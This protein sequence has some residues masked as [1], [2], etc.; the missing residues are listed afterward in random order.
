MTEWILALMLGLMAHEPAPWS[1]TYPATAAAIAN[2]A[3]EAP[4]FA[5]KDGP[6]RTAALLVSVAWFEGRFDP[7]AHNATDP[8]GGS[9]GMFQSSRRPIASAEEQARHALGALRVSFREC[10]ARAPQDWVAFYASGSCTNVGGLLA[11]RRRMGMAMKL[12][13]ER[14]YQPPSPI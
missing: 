9:F 11:S 5:G 12:Y 6:A 14:P 7:K 2:A 3:T 4:L 10:S 1:S 13:Q 8:G